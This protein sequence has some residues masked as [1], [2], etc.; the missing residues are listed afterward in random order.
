MS[1]LMLV[2]QQDRLRSR[3]WKLMT[4]TQNRFLP[5]IHAIAWCPVS[6]GDPFEFAIFR[7]LVQQLPSRWNYPI[8]A[9]PC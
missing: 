4:E 5:V 2:E 1:F 7:K 6:M 8:G 9:K 3:E